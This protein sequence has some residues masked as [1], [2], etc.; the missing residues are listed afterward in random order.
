M[1]K[2]KANI[3]YVSLEKGTVVPQGQADNPP[4]NHMYTQKLFY[5][6]E[7]FKEIRN[8]VFKSKK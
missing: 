7:N 5:D 3:K 1:E 2:N 4:N 6:P 8:W